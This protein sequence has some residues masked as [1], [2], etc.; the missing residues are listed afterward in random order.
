MR[1]VTTRRQFLTGTAALIAGSMAGCVSAEDALLDLSVIEHDSL[2]TRASNWS[3]E[4]EMSLS[5]HRLYT[6]EG[7]E[8]HAVDIARLSSTGEWFLDEV[9]LINWS[10]PDGSL[11]GE[12]VDWVYADDLAEGGTVVLLKAY[13]EVGSVISPDCENNSELGALLD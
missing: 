7:S 13:N 1:D 5:G 2:P 6:R 8:A 11:G 3:L 9:D 12:P 10:G 4:C